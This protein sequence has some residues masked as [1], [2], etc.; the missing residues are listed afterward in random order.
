MA[1]ARAAQIRATRAN[2]I[3]MFLT[4]SGRLK[5]EV[6][7]QAGLF[8]APHHGPQKHCFEL[9]AV[10]GEVTM[11]LAKNGNNLRYLKTELTV[12]VG[13][14]GSMTLRLVFPPFG[15]VRPNLDALPGEWSPIAR[16]ADGAGHPEAP[17]ADPLHDRRALMVVVGSARH[18]RGRCDALRAG[19]Q[20][21]P[22]NPGC[23]DGAAG[24]DKVAAVEYDDGHVNSSWRPCSCCNDSMATGARQP[25]FSALEADHLDAALTRS[26]RY[27]TYCA[28]GQSELAKECRD[29]RCPTQLHH[30]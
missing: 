15:R 14:R 18:R 7:F 22:G 10:I 9:T 25:E 6:R 8:R 17:F 26:H 3:P 27:S 20:Q 21:E 12:L 13:E 30:W 28:L 5:D 23:E 29:E 19:G 4:R 16:A 2:L 11:R 1:A 24:G